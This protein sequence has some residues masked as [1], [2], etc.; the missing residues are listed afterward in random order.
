MKINCIETI[1]RHDLTC[2][3]R[4]TDH[5][6]K[7]SLPSSELSKESRDQTQSYHQEQE[8]RDP[9]QSTDQRARRNEE[10]SRAEQRPDQTRP[11]QTQQRR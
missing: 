1:Y 9:E 5:D 10:Q 3:T 4:S 11:D 8:Q 7:K 2:N 6:R